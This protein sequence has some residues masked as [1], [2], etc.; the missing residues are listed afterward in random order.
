MSDRRARRKRKREGDDAVAENEAVT[1]KKETATRTR[2]EAELDRIKAS[3][4]RGEN[5][6]LIG[7]LV[8]YFRGVVAEVKKVTWPTREEAQR[9]TTIVL[10]VTVLA[11]VT[12]GAIDFFYG[13]WFQQGLENAGAYLLIGAIVLVVVGGLS[14]RFILR[15]ES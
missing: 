14:W 4:A 3:Q 2:E 1:A 12:L 8:A 13:W 11:S 7:R 9:L 5:L 10:F 6:P 15:E